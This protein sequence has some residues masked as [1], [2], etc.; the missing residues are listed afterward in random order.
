MDFCDAAKSRD[1]VLWLLDILDWKWR[2][3]QPS[4]EKNW[5]HWECFKR[6]SS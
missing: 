5:A 1:E 2:V 3:H 6:Q 4:D